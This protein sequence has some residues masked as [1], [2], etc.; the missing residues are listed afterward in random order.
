MVVLRPGV[1]DDPALRAAIART[2]ADQLGKPL[3]P[4]RVAVVPALPKTRSGKV[5]RRAIRSA[6]LGVDPGDL[7]SLDDPTTLAAIRER[8]LAATGPTESH[9]EGSNRD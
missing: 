9:L 2:V 8:A 5:M 4:E 7:S 1:A 6:W 3:K